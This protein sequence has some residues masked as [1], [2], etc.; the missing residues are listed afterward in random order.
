MFEKYPATVKL[1]NLTDNIDDIVLTPERIERMCVESCGFKMIYSSERVNDDILE[2]LSCLAEE[3]RAV[4]KMHAMQRGDVINTI[5]GYP[6][7]DRPVLHTAMRD[8]FEET[9]NSDKAHDATGLARKEIDKLKVFLEEIDTSEEFEELILVGIGGSDL[10]PRALYHALKAYQKPGRRVR[11]ISNVDPDD[12]AA[13]MQET[14]ITKALVVV[15]SKSGTTLETLTNEQLVK[16]KFV[17]AGLDIT[18]HFVAVT[19]EGSPMDNSEK[20][21]HCFYMWDYVGGRYSATSMVGG[22]M[23]GFAIGFENFMEVLKGAHDMDRTAL[24]KNMFE[25]P[26]LLSAMLGIWNRNFLK[27]QT[28]AI[29]PYSQALVRFTAHLQQC[30]MES[31]GKSIDKKG[32]PITY[33][34]GPIIWGE[35]GTN[36]QH[37]FYQLIHQG[38]TVVPV[39]FI[40]F[41]ES[42]YNDDIELEG[43]T[44]QEKLLA[45]LL[46]QS[47]ALSV[48]KNSDNPNKVFSGNR[49][50][51]L[52]LG[53]KLDPYSMGVLLAFYENKIAFQGFVWDI[54]S[55]DQEGVQLGKVLANKI[56]DIFRDPSNDDFP[57]GKAMVS[58]LNY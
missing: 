49:P 19:G 1:R 10:G 57:L 14:D 32:T 5:E 30:D 13:V 8:V 56:I 24:N 9:I 45:N 31:N 44:S 52:I 27:H 50:N 26:P 20:Y 55:F 51:R 17:A 47:V 4:E 37:S 28:V 41:S 43:T 33:E 48:G 35:P 58:H 29:I 18:K 12:A 46:A 21:R 40:G 23:L 39:E 42:Q 36:A 7:E 34:T 38:T 22:V 15:V 6:S 11:F 53:K 54:N 25:N 2:G 3:S 16:A